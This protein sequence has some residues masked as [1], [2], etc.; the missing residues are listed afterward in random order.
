MV[1][2][3]HSHTAYSHCGRDLPEVVIE[4]AIEHNIDCLG[5]TDHNYGI[6]A[7]KQEYLEKITALKKQYEKKI[8]LL[9]GIEIAT[10]PQFYDIKP[11]EIDGYDYC[12][13]EHIDREES[14]AYEDFFGFCEKMPISVGIAHTDLFGY[15]E[16]K[17]IN[18]R[19]FFGKMAQHGIFW[20][21]NVSYDS[22]HGYR[23]HEYYKEFF[24]NEKQQEIVKQAGTMLSVG[25]D[26]HRVE[27][28]RGDRVKEACAFLMQKGFPL[29][30]SF[31][32][33]D[34]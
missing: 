33:K 21:M 15:G 4:T 1:A 23:E 12:L 27:D 19:E 34:K 26:G 16:K 6:G 30:P 18:P 22:I 13:L 7:R 25:F 20:E 17:Q 8:I 31:V 28:Y 24:R 32:T 29:F 2:D 9:C 5:I 10:L 14:L 11:G 3:L